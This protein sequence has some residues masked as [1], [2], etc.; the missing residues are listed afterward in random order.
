M[1]QTSSCSWVRPAAG[2]PGN[3]SD[4]VAKLEDDLIVRQTMLNSLLDLP[5]SPDIVKSI[6][7]LKAEIA[8]I[9]KQL[10]ELTGTNGK[11][12]QAKGLSIFLLSFSFSF[13]FP[14]PRH[15]VNFK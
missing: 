2:Q 12:S 3:D 7:G 5:E 6:K 1:R 15:L 4:P 10:A 13:F 9:G 8:T 14:F 11:S